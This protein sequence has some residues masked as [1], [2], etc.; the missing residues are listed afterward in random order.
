MSAI[1]SR[2]HSESASTA[3]RTSPGSGAAKDQQTELTAV[4]RHER[5]RNAVEAYADERYGHVQLTNGFDLTSK[6]GAKALRVKLEEDVIG[7]LRHLGVT[8]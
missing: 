5:L 1:R 3:P 7:V 8:P 4:C 6:S 2:E